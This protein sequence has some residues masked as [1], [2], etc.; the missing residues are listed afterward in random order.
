MYL[1][2][3]LFDTNTNTQLFINSNKQEPVS[4]PISETLS[5]LDSLAI[6]YYPP[7]S[8][9]PSFTLMNEQELPKSPNLNKLA[10]TILDDKELP[11]SFFLDYAPTPPLP[12]SRSFCKYDKS[13]TRPVCQ[14]VHPIE[15]YK[16][17]N[18]F[19]RIET[20]HMNEYND[21]IKYKLNYP[22]LHKI[23]KSLSDTH[24]KI[25][26]SAKDD[27]IKYM[28][29][30]SHLTLNLKENLT[31]V[32]SKSRVTFNRSGS[33]STASINSRKQYL[34]E[35]PSKVR[36]IPKPYE[37]VMSAA[38]GGGSLPPPP[39]P[40]PP[41]SSSSNHMRHERVPRAQL[42]NINVE[43][44]ETFDTSNFSAAGGGGSAAAY[45]GGGSSNEPKGR[46]A[47]SVGKMYSLEEIEASYVAKPRDDFFSSSRKI[48]NEPVE[49]VHYPKVSNTGKSSNMNTSNW[50]N[51]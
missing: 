46:G 9:N 42:R 40:P 23:Y 30:E 36:N 29:D 22:S 50:R 1:K 5:E 44:N 18:H 45:G 20:I 3:S 27:A 2:S 11:E 33:S 39:P 7:L 49:K 21:I 51:N 43:S 8:L 48:G 4:E 26:K 28:H 15:W 47:S 24:L 12:T 32:E 37:S 41:Q 14:F 6:P 31:F 10:S 34:D 35:A 25:S 13:C 38:G 19:T 17:Y 16:L